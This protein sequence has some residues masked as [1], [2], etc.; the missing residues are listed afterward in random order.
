VGSGRWAVDS[1]KGVDVI[2]FYAMA[3]VIARMCNCYDGKLGLDCQN[4]PRPRF[5]PT[6]PTWLPMVKRAIRVVL[7]QHSLLVTRSPAIG[8][9]QVATN[10]DFPVWPRF[11]SIAIL[12]ANWVICD[13]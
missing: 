10:F 13:A 3:I 2:G 12:S 9:Q 6:V 7:E 1:E 4:W 8:W 5:T 11:F